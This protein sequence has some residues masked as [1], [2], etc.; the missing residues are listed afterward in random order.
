[1]RV[2]EVV[3]KIPLL[4]PAA[5]TGYGLAKRLVFRGSRDYWEQRYREGGNSGGGSFGRLA[6]FK[7]DV[8]NAFVEKHGVRSVLEF[9]CGDGH[10]LELAKYPRY[11]GLDV[12]PTA[13]AACA[14]RFHADPTKSFL[15]YSSSAFVD[16]LKVVSAEL[17]LSLDV[18]YHL[19]EDPIFEAYMTH[20][21]ASATRFVGIYSSDAVRFAA[22]PHVR[23]R[24]Y[25][26]WVAA[27]AP[28]FRVIERIE[29]PYP[30]N[31][32]TIESFASFAFYE[33]TA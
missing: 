4:G 3:R 24:K 11:I 10:Q 8:L 7:A 14:R 26:D 20:L 33:K 27:N 19:V 16:P 29:N 9:G 25:S 31:D 32:P 6:R 12:A 15:L 28:G 2:K 13:I 17:S 5:A 18:I 1:V 21:F 23:H 30:G 22:S